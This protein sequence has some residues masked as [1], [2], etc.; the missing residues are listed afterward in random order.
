[1]SNL[2]ELMVLLHRYPRGHVPCCDLPVGFQNLCDP[3]FEAGV[4]LCD[5]ACLPAQRSTCLRQLFCLARAQQRPL[6]TPGM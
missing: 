3:F 2:P 1:M 4:L 6:D 5:K